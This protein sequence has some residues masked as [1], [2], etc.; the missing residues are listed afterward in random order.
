MGR[1]LSCMFKAAGLTDI[2]VDIIQDKAFSGFGGDA[3][4]AWNWEVQWRSALPFSVKVFGGEQAKS[5]TQKILERFNDPEVFL[6]TSLFYVE[7][8]VPT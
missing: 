5:I 6:Y 4:R 7:G 8:G 1:K 2:K 3:E